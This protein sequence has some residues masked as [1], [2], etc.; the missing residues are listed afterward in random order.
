MI[1]DERSEIS[2][3][4]A[5]VNQEAIDIIEN[6]LDTDGPNYYLDAK[7]LIKL[8]YYRGYKVVRI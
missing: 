1:T 7:S 2:D 3:H 8:L 6:H 5:K 4:D